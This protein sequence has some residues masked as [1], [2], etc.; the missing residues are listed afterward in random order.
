[1]RVLVIENY[2]HCPIDFLAS[3]FADLG[4][5]LTILNVLEAHAEI[6]ADAL[7]QFDGL[8]VLGGAM[9]AYDD[10]EYPLIPKVVHL[11]SDFHQ[12]G[13][14]VFAI[15]LGAQMLARALGEPFKSNGHLEVGFVPLVLT[16][17][18]RQDVL[19]EGLSEGWSPI[20]WH[21]DNFH[22]PSGATLLMSGEACK[23]QAFKAGRASYAFQFH[24]EISGP[25]IRTMVEG[26]DAPYL[27]EVGESGR[28]LFKKMIEDVPEFIE[29][30]NRA[31]TR[32]IQNWVKLL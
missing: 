4:V 31:A 5:E 9:G 28:A 24:P 26:L 25:G 2:S 11:L 12:A 27:E 8:L 17:A 23:N 19:F 32:L 3:V 15:C 29:E 6:P 22:I 20:E 14:G 18:A 30:G 1:M 10:E 13:K 7:T 16:E 21:E